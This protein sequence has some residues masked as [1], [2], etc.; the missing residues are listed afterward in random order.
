[1]AMSLFGIVV[2]AFFQSVFRLEKNK[3]NIILFFKIH[4]LN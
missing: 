4:F 3:K 2:V 1:M